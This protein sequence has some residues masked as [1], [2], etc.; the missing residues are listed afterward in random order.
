[1]KGVTRLFIPSLLWRCP[2]QPHFNVMASPSFQD[3]FWGQDPSN[4]PSEDVG[5][6]STFTIQIVN[7]DMVP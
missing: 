7:R 1:M 3:S 2:L 5:H 4:I 6:A